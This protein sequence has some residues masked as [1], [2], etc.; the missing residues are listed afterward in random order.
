ML[1]FKKHLKTIFSVLTLGLMVISC[2]KE[3]EEPAPTGP[4]NIV[5][6]TTIAALKAKYDT[7]GLVRHI[8]EDLVIGGIVNM[9]DKSGNFYQ[10]IAI[11]DE[12]GGILL[13]LAGSNLYT[14]YPVG[15][16]IYVKLK[17]LYLGDYGRMIQ[18]GGGVDIVGG[19]VTLLAPNLKDQHI[20][21]GEYNQPLVPKLVTVSQLTTDLH[22]P[23]VNTLV[24]LEN[25]EFSAADTS[26][27]YAD[28]TMSGNRIIQGCSSPTTNRLT[29]R[30]SNF[31]NFATLPVPNG[32]GEIIG[33]YSVFN[34]TKQFTI[35]DTTDVRF[36][37]PR[38]S[39]SVGVIS[40]PA[41]SLGST[42]PYI[43]NFDNIGTALPQGV[44]VSTTSTSSAL[45]SAGSYTASKAAWNVT[46]AGFRNFASATGLNS[47]STIAEQDA[48][49]NRA[50]GVRQ[51]GTL[52]IGG[53]PGAAFLFQMENTTG[54]NNLKLEFQ[55]QSLD[56][57]SARVTTWKVDYGIGTAP[58]S[59]MEATASGTVTTGGNTWSNSPIVV[60][61]PAALN[62]QS[63]RVWIR[64]IA[65][66]QTTG[67]GSRASTAIDDVTFSWN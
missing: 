35:R 54:K 6:N 34:N 18:V 2:K 43:F 31:A 22:D 62:N 67:G 19:G 13:R 7:I 45:G 64:I 30:T 12:T 26:K 44:Y 37:G 41:F 32:N 61:F 9:D 58:T 4:A 5:A 59:F 51:T 23:Y 11:Q 56:A 46:T 65:T 17:G 15:R 36:N 14:T 16:K 40:G 39:A 50:L 29:L 1:I 38:C 48:S 21:L 49:T 55:L 52:E 42:S 3:F 10:Q 25:F 63:Q 66:S 60:N 53:D 57:S 20:I 24:R 33:I 28:P 8:E 47:G 27:A